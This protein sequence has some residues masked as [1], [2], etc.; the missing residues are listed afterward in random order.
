M[1]QTIRCS[2]GTG[3][4]LRVTPR[5]PLT[6]TMSLDFYRECASEIERN[7]LEAHLDAMIQSNMKQ[8]RQAYY[9]LG[10]RE[11]ASHEKPKRDWFGSATV[12][13]EWEKKL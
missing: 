8:I 5:D 7:L 12:L 4:Y 10:W 9:N 2:N 11:K 6:V 13:L 3:L 1:I